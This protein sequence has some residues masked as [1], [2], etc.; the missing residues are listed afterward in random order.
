MEND[1]TKWNEDTKWN[2]QFTCVLRKTPR[3]TCKIERIGVGKHDRKSIS[4]Q[5]FEV[6]LKWLKQFSEFSKTQANSW[7]TLQKDLTEHCSQFSV[8]SKGRNVSLYTE[9]T[10][11]FVEMMHDD[12]SVWWK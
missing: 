5:C 10:V 7:E 4:D 2:C 8:V 6:T 11:K 9:Y 1:D 12:S 3:N